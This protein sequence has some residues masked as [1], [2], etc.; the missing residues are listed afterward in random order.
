[1]CFS[2]WFQDCNSNHS[3]EL[4]PESLVMS[5]Q[6]AS[7]LSALLTQGIPLA[8]DQRSEVTL[9]TSK[10]NQSLSHTYNCS[11]RHPRSPEAHNR[12]GPHLGLE[13][14]HHHLTSCPQLYP[15]PHLSSS[16]SAGLSHSDSEVPSGALAS[17]LDPRLGLTAASSSRAG[18]DLLVGCAVV[19]LPLKQ[20]AHQDAQQPHKAEDRHN[21]NHRVL[22]SRLLRATC[23]RAIPVLPCLTTAAGS[24]CHLHTTSGPPPPL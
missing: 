14:H 11:L 7:C 15:M 22:S 19:A 1:M 16:L 23:P 13:S 4:K 12:A 24:C 8:P 10:A 20:V 21:G 6:D 2:L 17:H 3:L 5:A 9:N 18:P